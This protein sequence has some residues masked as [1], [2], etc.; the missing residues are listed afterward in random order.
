MPFNI[1]EA[2]KITFEDWKRNR[3][4]GVD[5]G[6]LVLRGRAPYQGGWCYLSEVEKQRI[7]EG[8]ARIYREMVLDMLEYLKARIEE[9]FSRSQDWN[10][11]MELELMACK[12]A[13]KANLPVGHSEVEGFKHS[14]LNEIFLFMPPTKKF[15]A[16]LQRPK[17]ALP[18]DYI[19]ECYRKKISNQPLTMEIASIKYWEKGDTAPDNLTKWVAIIQMEVVFQYWNW[20]KG[21]HSTKNRDRALFPLASKITK[22]LAFIQKLLDLLKKGQKEDH[23]VW[24][25]YHEFSSLFLEDKALITKVQWR[26]GEAQLYYLF[27]QLISKEFV[28]EGQIPSRLSKAFINKKG[29]QFKPNQISS[30]Y[31]MMSEKAK[32][33]INSLIEILLENSKGYQ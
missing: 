23:F 8:Q 2:Q 15:R 30:S 21:Y 1:E 5:L 27:D 20:L 14:T 33:K 13:L 10:Y 19:H 6:C 4:I 16:I 12:I 31:Q 25:E 17:E 29:N 3:I 9:K 26:K 7:K 22:P 24:C 28:L 11:V 18:F 32:N